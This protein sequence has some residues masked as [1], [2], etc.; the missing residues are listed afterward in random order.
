VKAARFTAPLLVAGTLILLGANAIPSSE[1]KRILRDEVHR[2]ERE[3]A[4]EEARAKR[5]AAEVQALHTDDFYL[6]RLCVE[7]W[8]LTPAGAV[9]FDPEGAPPAPADI[10]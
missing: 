3:L 2:L 10:E 8:S 5:L 9:P 6:E 7:T 1:R 4:R